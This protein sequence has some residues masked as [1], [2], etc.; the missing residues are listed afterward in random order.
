MKTMNKFGAL[1]LASAALS[2]AQPASASDV[3]A[4]VSVVNPLA[5]G[6]VVSMAFGD[7]VLAPQPDR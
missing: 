2:F 7:I 6:S 1:L 4:F 3:D 5:I